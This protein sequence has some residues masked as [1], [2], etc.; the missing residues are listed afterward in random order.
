M[1]EISKCKKTFLIIKLKKYYTSSESL[2]KEKPDYDCG[3]LH[4]KAICPFKN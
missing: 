3:G 2:T 1:S 4:F